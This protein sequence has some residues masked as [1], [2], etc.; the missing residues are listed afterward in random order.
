[1]TMAI[2]VYYFELNKKGNFWYKNSLYHRDDDLP[3]I[4]YKN[5]TKEWYQNGNCHR[6]NYLPAVEYKNGTKEWYKNGKLH[7]D[8]DLPAIQCNNGKKFWYQNGKLHRDGD[9]PA[10]EY[11]NGI[12]YWYKNGNIHRDNNLPSIIFSDGDKMW[13]KDGIQ[14]I[15]ELKFIFKES[16]SLEIISNNKCFISLE[17]FKQGDNIVILKCCRQ[18]VLFHCYKQWIVINSKCP[19][20]RQKCITYEYFTF[21]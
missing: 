4:E 20:C 1:M 14:Y 17:E 12:K 13:F 16:L 8:G 6:D 2:S 10:I 18:M 11:N 7:R 9:L 21:E 5:G 3:A 19:H 15:P